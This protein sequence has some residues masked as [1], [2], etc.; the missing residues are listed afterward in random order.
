MQFQGPVQ[1]PFTLLSIL[2]MVSL[3]PTVIFFVLFL[4][5]YF[6]TKQQMFAFL[7]TTFALFLIQHFFAIQQVTSSIQTDAELYFIL[8]QI[9]KILTFYCILIVM[10]MFERNTPYSG[11]VTILT[12]LMAATLGVIISN[13]SV[14]TL[15]ID[16]G[17]VV[18]FGHPSAGRLLQ[19]L[20]GLVAGLWILLVLFRS[21]KRAKSPKQK[22]LILLIFVGLFFCEILGGTL[23][24]AVDQIRVDIMADHTILFL[25]GSFEFNGTI[26]MLIIAY[27][28]YRASKQPWLLQRQRVHLLLVYSKEGLDLYS[29]IYSDEISSSDVTLLTGGFTAVTSMFQEATKTGDKVQ[30]IQ[31]EGRTLR[32]LNRELF[33]SALLV[34]YTTQASELAL[35]KFTEEFE[36]KFENELRKFAGNVSPFEKA[37]AIAEQYF[38]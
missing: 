30:A 21:Y 22:R 17:W 23:P 33:V 7:A 9:F 19:G 3:I 24:V 16:G 25:T 38:S 2:N 10:E 36:K 14:T 31:F 32:L 5:D 4:R 20:F 6:K 27:A 12:A 1:L 11:R 29:R 35:Q 37:S 15:N 8:S 26:G 34:D 18:S 28:F 13:P